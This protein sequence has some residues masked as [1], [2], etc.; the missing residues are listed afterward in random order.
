[1][2]L[3]SDQGH[4]GV[5]TVTD[6]RVIW[7]ATITE[8]FNVSVPYGV[9]EDVRVQNSARFG[10]R[11][12]VLETS[13]RG[14]SYLLGFRVDTPEKLE[15]LCKEITAVRAAALHSPDYGVE[16]NGASGDVSL[17]GLGSETTKQTFAEGEGV[18]ESDDRGGMGVHASV[19]GREDPFAAYY[20][21]LSRSSAAADA[22]GGDAGGGVEGPQSSALGRATRGEARPPVYMATLGLAVEELPEGLTLDALWTAV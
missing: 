3:S 14:N 16:F 21:G 8:N 15:Q 9:L 11:L 2:N 12:L 5:L 20:A 6:K 1:M 19:L 18:E 4:L 10:G 22:M 13:P 17:A 7:H